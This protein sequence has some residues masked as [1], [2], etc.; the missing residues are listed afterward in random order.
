MAKNDDISAKCTTTTLQQNEDICLYSLPNSEGYANLLCGN[1]ITHIV[2]ELNQ[3]KEIVEYKFDV[4]PIVQR[5]IDASCNK[6]TDYSVYKIYNKR[7][8]VSKK[9]SDM[10]QNIMYW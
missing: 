2:S 1:V 4:T 8:P 6:M 10:D 7:M 9:I 3:G 5:E